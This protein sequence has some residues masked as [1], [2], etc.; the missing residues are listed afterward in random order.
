MPNI[1]SEYGEGFGFECQSSNGTADGGAGGTGSYSSQDAP[2]DLVCIGFGPASLAIAIALHDRNINARVL[3]LER[4]PHFAWHSGMLLP[5]THMQI[6]FLKDLATLRNP[7]SEFTFVNYLHN[8]QRLVTFTNL[9]T[10]LPLREEYNDYMSWC[11]GHF[12]D[13]VR[14]SVEV[15]EVSPV[16][17]AGG[18]KSWE[19]STRHLSNGRISVVK[20]RNVVIAIGGRP[21]LPASITPHPRIIHS[22][23]YSTTI[24]SLLTDP[25]M[26]YRIAVVGAGQSS[27][28]IFNDLHARFPAAKTQLFIRQHALK[29]SDDSPFVN[30]IFDPERVE[31]VY[32]MRPDIRKASLR[33]DKATN[34][35]VVRLELLE[36]LYNKMY[37]QKLR[38]PDE[39]KWQHRIQPL[40]DVVGTEWDW[41]TGGLR[42]TLKNTRTGELVDSDAKFD[43]VIFGTGYT[44]DVHLQMLKQVEGLLKDGCC[45]VGR[46]YR[47]AFRDGVVAEGT[48]IFL[49]GCCEE[50]HGLSDTLLSILAVRAGEIVTSIFGPGP[51]TAPSAAFRRSKNETP[52]LVM[53]DD[54]SPMVRKFATTASFWL[55]IVV[56]IFMG[57]LSWLLRGASKDLGGFM[58]SV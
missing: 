29:P 10:F 39:S 41:K 9:S 22:S 3:F 6:S 49:Q 57:V 13:M 20:A 24:P 47:L 46:D 18:V 2:Y 25:A 23:Q 26:P 1:D 11:A 16:K 53:V 48:N 28:E 55:G 5:G 45:S 14:Y 52:S 19:V 44:R 4:Q 54:A 37:A 58:L 8:Q 15:V 38:E 42:L 51:D 34:Y 27:A 17:G 32:G 7:R 33:E 56:A 40:R 43:A 21:K 30:E 35:S 12:K 50:T 36:A 31:V